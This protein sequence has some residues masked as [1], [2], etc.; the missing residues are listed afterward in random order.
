MSKII[1]YKRDF[2][3]WSIVT[4]ILSLLL[5]V[6]L[7]AIVV[8]LFAGVG[9]MWDHIVDHFLFDYVSNSIILIVGAGLLTLLLG[10]SS[11][12]I[13][14]QYDFQGRKVINAL[15]YLPLAIP[16]YIVAYCYV[17]LF[18]HDGTVTSIWKAIGLPDKIFYDGHLQK[19]DDAGRYAILN[20]SF[21]SSC[22][23]SLLTHWLGSMETR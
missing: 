16:S 1:H 14:S 19:L 20:L 18:D 3:K 4:I 21:C 7:F 9:E 8:Y 17:G 23:C 5:T 2:S 22:S 15:L 10:V 6:P 12:W 13:V 11:A